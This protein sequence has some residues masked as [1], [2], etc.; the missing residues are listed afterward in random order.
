MLSVNEDRGMVVKTSPTI[1]FRGILVMIAVSTVIAS[2]VADEDA[3]SGHEIIQ[4]FIDVSGGREAYAKI[5]NR[6]IAAQLDLPD[7]GMEGELIEIITPPDY[8]RVMVFD[9]YDPIVSGISDGVPWRGDASG[10][11]EAVDT[12]TA[13][14]IVRHGQLN[15]FLD[16]TRDS[17]EATVVG[18]STVEDDE[19]FLVEIKP[20]VGST[21][22]AFFS[23]ETGLL[24]RIDDQAT[25]MFRHF[26]DYREKDGVLVPYDVQIVAGMFMFGLKFVAI[27]HNVD[28][29]EFIPDDLFQTIS[30]EDIVEMIGLNDDGSLGKSK[31]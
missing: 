5:Q 14:D 17:G 6:A 9:V 25:S 3:P 26:D 31:D 21:L 4:R 2:A 13:F 12:V 1:N 24:R 29:N 20:A 16:W 19:C 15:P 30:R 28:F 10:E 27:E 7:H 22:V 11:H 18:E 23:K 8:R